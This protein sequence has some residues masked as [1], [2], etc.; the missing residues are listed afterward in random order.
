MFSLLSAALK[1]EVRLARRFIMEHRSSTKLWRFA[2]VL[3]LLQSIT[4]AYVVERHW[5]VRRDADN[6]ENAN[7]NNQTVSSILYL[8]SKDFIDFFIIGF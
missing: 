5:I 1:E 8:S 3:C 6:L 7:N 2:A 4:D